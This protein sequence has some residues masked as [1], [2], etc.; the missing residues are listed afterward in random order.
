MERSVRNLG[1]P[2]CSRKKKRAGRAIQSKKRTLDGGRESDQ[3][4]VL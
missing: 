2:A 1:D 3:P 4:I